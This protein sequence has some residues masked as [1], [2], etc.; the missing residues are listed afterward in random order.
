MTSIDSLMQVQYK[1][2]NDQL[3]ATKTKRRQA[4]LNTS[5]CNS[6]S[7]HLG[8]LE[9]PRLALIHFGRRVHSRGWSCKNMAIYADEKVPTKKTKI[10][11][12]FVIQRVRLV[13]EGRKKFFSNLYRSVLNAIHEAAE[14]IK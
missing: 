5:I 6:S 10:F 13:K 4:N 3:H 1:S 9:F 11:I 14:L 12:V 8:E 2:N 7:S